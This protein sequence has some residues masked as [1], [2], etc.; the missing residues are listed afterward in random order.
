MLATEWSF[1]NVL[2]TMVVFFFWV[3]AIWLFIALFADIFRRDDLSGWG[4]AGW[5]ILLLVAP[6]L[7]ALIYIIAR[8]KMTAQDQRLLGES[9]EMNRRMRGYS[10][11]DEVTKLAKLRD[12]GEISA[13]DYERL[14]AQA[15]TLT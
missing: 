8:P 11:A 9:A 1:G 4:K 5:V 2:W 6:F 7:G 3:M 13:E 12:D 15:L 14:K 10:A